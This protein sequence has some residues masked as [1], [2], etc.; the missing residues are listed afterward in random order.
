MTATSELATTDENE[1]TLLEK[2]VNQ[3]LPDLGDPKQIIN[4]DFSRFSEEVRILLQEILE[5]RAQIREQALKTAN[6]KLPIGTPGVLQAFKADQTRTI[7]RLCEMRTP[8]EGRLASLL[9]FKTH[10]LALHHQG[11]ALTTTE[12]WR[13]FSPGT[14]RHRNNQT[15]FMKE[16]GKTNTPQYRVQRYVSNWNTT[17]GF[18]IKAERK[19]PKSTIRKEQIEC[20]APESRIK[21]GHYHANGLKIKSLE[22][23]SLTS[24]LTQFRDE[25]KELLSQF[26]TTPEPQ[27]PSPTVKSTRTNGI[28]L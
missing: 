14:K 3:Q 5:L 24:L 15:I 1:P 26:I 7:N 22:G 13:T 20:S 19:D 12:Q 8:V 21:K 9:R 28:C 2:R 25:L 27:Q 6:E 11:I 4:T 23:E 16:Y 17:N 10:S 18:I